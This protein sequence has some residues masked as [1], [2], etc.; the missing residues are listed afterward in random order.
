MSA[1]PKSSVPTSEQ[2][3]ET[4]CF[5]REVLAWWRARFGCDE[6]EPLDVLAA[7]AA[8][9]RSRT[10]SVR[11]SDRARRT[12]STRPHPEEAQRWQPKMS[13]R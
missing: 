12:E 6:A 10:T 2:E 4:R 7:H 11:S 8:D 3:T 1:L 13:K 5:A 9:N